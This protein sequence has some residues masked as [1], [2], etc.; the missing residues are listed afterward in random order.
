M[1]II[2]PLLKKAGLALILSNF[3][4]VSNLSFLSKVVECAVL[5]QFNEHC[6]RNDLIPDYQSA[7]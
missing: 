1:A 7:Y 6:T 5:K 3:H 4:P 2:W